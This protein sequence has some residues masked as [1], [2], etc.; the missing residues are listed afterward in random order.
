MSKIID[1]QYQLLQFQSKI[2]LMNG[3]EFQSFFEKL[4]KKHNK[5]FKKI[6]SGGGDGGNDGWIKKLELIIKFTL[7]LILR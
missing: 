5:L 7:Q 3:S 2:F 4:I 1:K 6:P